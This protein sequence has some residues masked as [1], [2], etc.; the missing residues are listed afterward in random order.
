MVL[1]LVSIIEDEALIAIEDAY[2]SGYKAALLSAAPDTA[3]WKTLAEHWKAEAESR[4]APGDT[5]SWGPIA[6]ALTAG[7]SL[8]VLLALL[9][10]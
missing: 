5:R 10:R 1:E 2:A 7:F 8:G 9:G 6:T 3:Y 4:L